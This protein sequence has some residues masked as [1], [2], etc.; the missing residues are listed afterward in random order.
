MELAIQLRKSMTAL[1]FLS[2]VGPAEQVHLKST[3]LVSCELY[4]KDRVAGEVNERIRTGVY[5]GYEAELC[6]DN[7]ALCSAAVFQQYKVESGY[8]FEIQSNSWNEIPDEVQ[9]AVVRQIVYSTWGH[10]KRADSPLDVVIKDDPLEASPLSYL[11]P[12]TAECYL[13]FAQPDSL[14]G[15]KGGD[16][17]GPNCWFTAISALADHRSTYARAQL[18]FPSA[19]DKSRFMGP[20][21]F[22][23]HLQQ[24]TQVQEP[25]F[26][27]I[28]RYYTEEPIYGGFHNLIYGGEVHAAV[29]VGKDSY[30]STEGQS[31]QREIALTKNG[32]SDLDFLI[33]QD[34][35]SLDEIYLS[36]PSVNPAETEG[37]RIKKGYFRVK[38]GASVLDP[39]E[40]G[41]LSTAHGGYLVDNKNYA[42]R[43]LCLA[44]LITPPPGD[45]RSCYNYP[46]EWMTLPIPISTPS[47][48]E[49]TLKI[50]KAARLEPFGPPEVIRMKRAKNSG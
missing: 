50:G 42:D 11:A 3:P 5:D 26:G 45:R 39:V 12:K 4:D 15:A 27:D 10:P 46:V 14:V 38:R 48:L 35:H 8:V 23:L 20:T 37:Q 1:T 17:Y 29:Y 24:F 22:R 30:V 32:R 28:I 9:N 49:T 7:P 16:A 31:E 6:L 19:W 44:K 21:E 47:G 2:S 40:Y 13:R 34:V 18:L 36:P 25:Q 41:M 43:W 33:F